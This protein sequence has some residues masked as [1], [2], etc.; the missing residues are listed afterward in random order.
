MNISFDIPSERTSKFGNLQYYPRFRSSNT[1][2][3]LNFHR[4]HPCVQTFLRNQPRNSNF[5]IEQTLRIF[6]LQ[7]Y[8]PARFIKTGTPSCQGYLR[9]YNFIRIATWNY[10]YRGQPIRRAISTAAAF[11][12]RRNYSFLQ[13]RNKIANF[14]CHWQAPLIKGRQ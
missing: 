11:D 4:I 7:R 13:R 6:K 10:F 3:C 8:N 12:I 5:P 2:K 9:V 14:L 1:E